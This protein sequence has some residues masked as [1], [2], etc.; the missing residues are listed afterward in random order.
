MISY[1]HCSPSFHSGPDVELIQ[2]ILAQVGKRHKD[3]G[4]QTSYFPHMGE[5]LV[6]GLEQ[7]MGS[8]SFLPVHKAAWLEVYEEMSSEIVKSM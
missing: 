3:F 2:E 7:V 1:T 8:A 6:Y 5:A 4:V